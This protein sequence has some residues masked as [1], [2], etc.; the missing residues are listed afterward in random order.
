[1]GGTTVDY[2]QLA[3]AG[4]LLHRQNTHTDRMRS[5][6]N[7]ECRLSSGDLGLVLQVLHPATELVTDIAE[8]AL[9]G[10]GSIA[11]WAAT[12]ATTTLDTYVEADRVAYEAARA[13]LSSLGGGMPPFADP[14]GA[15]P[16]LGG[17]ASSADGYGNSPSEWHPLIDGILTGTDTI[18]SGVDLVT[19]TADTAIDRI[20]T[21]GS[22][23]GVVER[24]D[25]TSY[26]VTPQIDENFMEDLRWNA[27]VILGSL[28]WIAERIFHVSILKEYVFKPL[29]GDWQAIGS[30]A[31]AWRHSGRA[32]M[33]M[34]SNFSGLPGQVDTWRGNASLAFQAAMAALSAATVGLSYAFDFVGGL[35]DNVRTVAKLACSGIAAALQWISNKLLKIAAKAALPVVGWAMIA[36]EAVEDIQKVMFF[37][38][39]I[40]T[41]I[42]SILDAIADF[43]DAR[44][45]LVQAV[46]ILEDLLT[47]AGTRVVR[48]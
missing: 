12:T 29:G 31:D 3:M 4:E 32:L 46:F 30:S 48:A 16:G 1:M 44:E 13:L 33:E 35:V 39:M 9:T 43:I 24:T 28:D 26:L 27:G 38:R 34:S 40:N 36:F 11:Q 22:R 18:G 47:N 7:T 6:L 15:L 2:G 42:T 20:S 10:V 25:P 5:Y 21:L 23:G 45:K 41:L 14:R 8:N 19:G 17:A 37:L